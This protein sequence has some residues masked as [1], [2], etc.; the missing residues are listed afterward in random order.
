MFMYIYILYQIYKYTCTSILKS[1]FTCKAARVL[2]SVCEHMPFNLHALNLT[3]HAYGINSS[4]LTCMLIISLITL[5]MATPT[6]QY[7]E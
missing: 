1:H 6:R 3:E 4:L 2:F 7:D 5:F